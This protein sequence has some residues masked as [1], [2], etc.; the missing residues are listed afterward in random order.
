M[1]DLPP[2]PCRIEPDRGERA[3]DGRRSMAESVGAR[4][5]GFT[6]RHNSSELESL[7]Q[8]GRI[9]SVPHR[10]VTLTM[11]GFALNVAVLEGPRRTLSSSFCAASDWKQIIARL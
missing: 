4:G 2:I 1:L 7:A 10:T 11:G 9:E 6:V 3:P 8:Q 5:A